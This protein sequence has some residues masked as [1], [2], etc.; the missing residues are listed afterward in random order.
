[1]EKEI[2]RPSCITED[3]RK[4]YIQSISMLEYSKVEEGVKREYVERGEPIDPPMYEVTTVGGGKV[5]LPLDGKNLTVEDNEE[6]TARRTLEWQSHINALNRM[7]AEV[8]AITQDIVLEG[9]LAIPPMDDAWIEKR[10]KRK[11]I[12]PED[13]EELLKY[14]KMT[15]IL[16]T[17]SDYILA[18]GAIMV[19][20]SSGAIKQ[21]DVDAAGASFLRQVQD[22]AGRLAKPV[23]NV[24]GNGSKATEVALDT[25]PILKRTRRGKRVGHPTKPVESVQS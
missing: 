3:G 22:T 18:Q 17:P 6:E 4:V 23:A 14:Y 2:E 10:R 7:R 1:M 11:I 16:R 21:E 5:K 24:D 9:V 8:G 20:S 15:E 19:L 25:Q 13:P 12:L